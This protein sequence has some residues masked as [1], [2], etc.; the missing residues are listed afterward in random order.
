MFHA[1]KILTCTINMPIKSQWDGKT[2]SARLFLLISNYLHD[3][4]K[5]RGNKKILK[6]YLGKNDCKVLFDS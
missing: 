5:H 1:M 3:E 6:T 4:M 2:V